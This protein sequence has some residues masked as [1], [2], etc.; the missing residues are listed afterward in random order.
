M[1]LKQT[2]NK[3]NNE[4]TKTSILTDFSWISIQYIL[5]SAYLECTVAMFTFA[6]LMETRLIQIVCRAYLHPYVPQGLRQVCS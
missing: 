4:I 1:N 3:V 2:N 6:S 5:R